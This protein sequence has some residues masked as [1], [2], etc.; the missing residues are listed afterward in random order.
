MILDSNFLIGT[1]HLAAAD[2]DHSEHRARCVY[3]LNRKS[4]AQIRHY[5]PLDVA[6]ALSGCGLVITATSTA[7]PS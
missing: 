4:T 6:Q 7:R 5:S 2:R 1:P 3:E